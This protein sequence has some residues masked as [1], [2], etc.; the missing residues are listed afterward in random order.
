MIRL[1]AIYPA[2]EGQT[3]DD[4]YFF[5]NHHKLCV[6]RLKPEGMVSCQF[7]KGLSDA[8]G[9]KPPY[10]AIA[11][12]VFNSIDE[13]QKA[14]AKHGQEIMADIPNYS[15]LQPVMQISEITTS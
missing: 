5:D 11:H 3:F 13:F 15:K 4:A 10:I 7:D 12:V 6:A 14:M 8:A 1:T 9:G 2:T